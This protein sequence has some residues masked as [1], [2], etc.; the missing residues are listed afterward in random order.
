MIGVLSKLVT[1]FGFE[2][3]TSDVL[4][5]VDLSGLAVEATRRWAGDGIYANAVNPGAIA[6]G[7]AWH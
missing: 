6:T 4:Q 5:G 2:S 7:T 3:T 1:P